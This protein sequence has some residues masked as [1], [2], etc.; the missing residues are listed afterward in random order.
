MTAAATAAG[1]PM[2][3][4]EPFPSTPEQGEAIGAPLAPVLIVA[5]AGTGKTTVM[6]QR[7]LHLVSAGEARADQVLG[8]TFTNKAALNLKEQVRTALGP[9]ADVTIATYHSFGASIVADHAL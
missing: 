3:G 5:G 6:A 9:D 4:G 8:L 2:T 7:I 1:A